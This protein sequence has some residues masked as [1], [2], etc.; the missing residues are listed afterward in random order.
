MEDEAAELGIQ[1]DRYLAGALCEGASEFSIGMSA[2]APEWRNE[3]TL[4][5]WKVQRRFALLALRGFP[6]FNIEACT[7]LLRFG[8][9]LGRRARA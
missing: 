5:K 9:N 4:V 3:P 2:S 8:P 7:A 1:V 6:G